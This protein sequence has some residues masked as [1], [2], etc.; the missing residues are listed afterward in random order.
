MMSGWRSI[1]GLVMAA[2]CLGA[3]L[4]L[5]SGSARGERARHEAKEDAAVRG[6]VNIGW[7]TAIDGPGLLSMEAIGQTLAK[8][9]GGIERCYAG[10]LRRDR[11][12]QGRVTVNMNIQADGRLIGL[13]LFDNQAGEEVGGCIFESLKTLRFP[14]P[15]GGHVVVSC[16]F[17]FIS[18]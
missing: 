9:R 2:A 15:T 13:S 14:R 4:T 7:P 3:C 8:T 18:R 17:E 1:H 10:V 5:A 6:I 11:S 16:P 12:K